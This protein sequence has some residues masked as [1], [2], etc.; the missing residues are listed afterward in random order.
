[1]EVALFGEAEVDQCA[2]AAVT[3]EHPRTGCLDGSRAQNLGFLVDIAF[4]CPGCCL[5]FTCNRIIVDDLV[6]GFSDLFDP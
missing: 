4:T 1:M 6:L 5:T 3:I 2:R